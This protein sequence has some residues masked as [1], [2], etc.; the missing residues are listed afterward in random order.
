MQ[1]VDVLTPERVLTDVELGSKKRILVELAGLMADE[2]ADVGARDL[3]ESLCARESIGSTGLGNGI[4]IPHARLAVPGFASA[5][6]MRLAEPVDFDATD[7][8]P[9]DVVFALAVSEDAAG[10]QMEM[11]KLMAD[12][13]GDAQFCAR[14]RKTTDAAELFRLLTESQDYRALA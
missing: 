10:Q 9:V 12:M 11:L 3:F 14:I 7:N 4:A 2:D 6:F 1:L 13:F 8:Q 5:A